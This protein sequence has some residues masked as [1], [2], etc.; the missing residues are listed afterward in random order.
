MRILYI[1]PR[2]IWPLTTGA[3]LR[4]YHFVRALGRRAEL[5][6][7]Y[8]REAGHDDIDPLAVEF[9]A[10]R[11]AVPPPERYTPIKLLRGLTT[12]YPVTV[13]NYT[14]PAMQAVLDNIT[15]RQSF[16]L[17]HL[18]GLH[19]AAFEPS[20][21]RS[22]PNVP[23]I[24]N[25]H[26][27][28]SELMLRYS[29][30]S[31]L[32]IPRR[33]YARLTASRIRSLEDRVL[34]HTFGHL[35]CSRRE[36]QVL[37]TRY[38]GSRIAAIE[39]GVDTAYFAPTGTAEKSRLLFVG[40]MDYHA[41]I[42]GAQWFVRNVW[43]GVRQRYPHLRFTIAGARPA[44]SVRALAQVEGVEVTGTV[45][46]LRPYYATAAVAIVPLL[47]G[48]GTRLKILEAM[49]AGV[50]VVSTTLGAEGLDVESG[51][52]I[53]IADAP[54]QWLPAL[55]ALLET[56]EQAASLA[57]AGTALV[58]SRYDWEILGQRLWDTY[59]EWLRCSCE[60][61]GASKNGP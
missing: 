39:N 3:R 18:D 15:S 7:V 31:S 33:A 54:G 29:E 50:P 60:L 44:E 2:L 53:R 4:D 34:Q 56:P 38:P 61:E 43:E 52:D 36:R 9:C 21:R 6:L 11:H 1:T 45:P 17:I 23:V 46:D 8:Y 47:T 40:S 35:V 19:L 12:R 49:A 5:T 57:A 41:N 58:R 16:D 59:N 30:Q 55:T 32:S 28:D 25:W 14:T 13:W 22:Y 24:Y 42:E 51:R 20:L 48:S 26:N 37:Q 27:I 10:A